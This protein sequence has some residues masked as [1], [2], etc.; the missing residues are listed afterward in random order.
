MLNSDGI[1]QQTEKRSTREERQPSYFKHYEAHLNN[2]SITS[3]FFTKILDEPVS[4]E[5]F[6]VHPKW[7]STMQEEINALKKIR[8]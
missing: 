2:Y 8:R 7:E 6:K 3:C 1:E 5:E 4:F